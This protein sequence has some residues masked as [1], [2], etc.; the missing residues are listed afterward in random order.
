MKNTP[1]SIPVNQLYRDL[2]HRLWYH[3][4]LWNAEVGRELGEKE[5]EHLLFENYPKIME[6]LHRR[7]AASNLIYSENDFFISPE[8]NEKNS[9]DDRNLL[10]A[11]AKSWL[12]ADG[13]WF[14]SVEKL[15]GMA[16]AKKINDLCWRY[17]SPHEAASIR[18]LTGISSSPGLDGLRQALYLRLYSFINEQE[19]VREDENTLCFFMNN[20]RVQSARSRKGLA[21]YPCKSAG[22]VEYSFF[23]S[24][25][26]YRIT[27]ECIA[28]P[29]DEHPWDWHCGW[30]FSIK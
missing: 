9:P 11:V 26:D 14:Q 12:A 17:F 4:F 22:V 6:N 30:K 19:D 5:R 21:F 25:V 2:L 13:I 10:S 28:C 16:T 23:A 7:T 1:V 8:D 15:E 24:S 27:T 20:C 3:H 18:H 29:P